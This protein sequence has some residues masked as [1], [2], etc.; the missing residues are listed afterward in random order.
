MDSAG[1]VPSKVFSLSESCIKARVFPQSA[2]SSL[3]ARVVPSR[4]FSLRESCTKEEDSKILF[5]CA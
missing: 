5:F 3:K 4:V 2:C 1:V